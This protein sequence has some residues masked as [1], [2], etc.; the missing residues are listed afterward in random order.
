M[1]ASM[2][3]LPTKKRQ[4]TIERIERALDRLAEIIVD[5]GEDGKKLLPIYRRLEEEAEALRA[6]QSLLD[7]VR[8]RLS[9]SEH[10]RAA[11]S[12]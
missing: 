8:R 10:R 12:A 2:T 7:Q 3:A 6:D 5:F 1:K 9:Q 11:R 4:V